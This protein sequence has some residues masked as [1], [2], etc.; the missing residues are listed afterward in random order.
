MNKA[1]LFLANATSA[2]SMSTWSLVQP[3]GPV[4]FLI[5]T[6]DAWRR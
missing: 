1:V 6:I 5:R 4:L 2:I 3:G